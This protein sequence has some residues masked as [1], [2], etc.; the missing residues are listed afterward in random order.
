MNF[1]ILT[2]NEENWAT[3]LDGGN[4]WGVREDNLVRY[5]KKL[6]K[7]DILRHKATGKRCVV[8]EIDPDGTIIVTTQD[9]EMRSYKPHELE[10]YKKRA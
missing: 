10:P 8:R 5:W 9:D 6:D 2:G 7:G 3:A 4:I 1:W